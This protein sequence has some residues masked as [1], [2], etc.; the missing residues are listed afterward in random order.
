M[1][2][3]RAVPQE[4]LMDGNL[5]GRLEFLRCRGVARSGEDWDWFMNSV[6]NDRSYIYNHIHRALCIWDSSEQ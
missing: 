6:E 3:K 1:S 4:G 5:T 2:F